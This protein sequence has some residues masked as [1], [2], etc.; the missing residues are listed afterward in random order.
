MTYRHSTKAL[1]SSQVQEGCDVP[2]R[3]ISVSGKLCP[4]LSYSAADCEFDVNGSI[5][6]IKDVV[7]KQKHT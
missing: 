4:G 6:Y 2:Y 7:F 3:K 5:I 1:S